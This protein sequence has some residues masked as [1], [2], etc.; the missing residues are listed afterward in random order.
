MN[1]NKRGLTK[2]KL[3]KNYK[4]HNKFNKITRLIQIKITQIKTFR[5]MTPKLRNNN[6]LWKKKLINMPNCHSMEKE[7]PK[8][9][10]KLSN[11]L[12]AQKN[13]S[14]WP[15]L[16]STMVFLTKVNGFKE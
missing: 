10:I 3:L 15:K 9:I 16:T 1:T 2:A 14:N 11:C 5:M 6:L 13:L 4:K 7:R 12:L 8:K